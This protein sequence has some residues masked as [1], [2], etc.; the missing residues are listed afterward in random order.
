MFWCHIC[1]KNFSIQS[2]GPL[3]ILR[4]HRTEKHLKRDQR[5]RYEH[6]KS[7]DPISGKLQHRVRGC[8]GKLLTKIELAKELPKFIHVDL[9]D[10]EERFPFF[11]DFV[12]GRTTALVTPEY[13]AKLQLTIVGDFLQTQ[14]DFSVLRIFWAGV[15]FYTDYRA[16]LCDFDWTEE[17]ITVSHF[18]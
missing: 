8:N 16:S 13:R 10:V 15:S 5:W 9:V 6:L 1:K 18:L 17:H 14:E 11:D 3:E 12:Q 7:V 4:H 2:N